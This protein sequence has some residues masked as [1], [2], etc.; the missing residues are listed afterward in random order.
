MYYSILSFYTVPWNKRGNDPLLRRLET[1]S[2]SALWYRTFSSFL[3][4][5]LSFF[6]FLLL[7]S[8]FFMNSLDWLMIILNGIHDQESTPVAEGNRLL[9][10]IIRRRHITSDNRSHWMRLKSNSY[11]HS[12]DIWLK[13]IESIG[14]FAAEPDYMQLLIV[15]KRCR[16]EHQLASGG[17]ERTSKW[18]PMV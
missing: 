10:V 7:F 9:T 2:E 16:L 3:S 12:W 18:A 15:Y 17:S 8:S 1:C 5:F 11:K 14:Q 4:F 6:L 13:D